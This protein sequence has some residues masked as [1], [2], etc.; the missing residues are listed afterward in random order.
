MGEM[1]GS[2]KQISVK[3]SSRL[4]TLTD[5]MTTDYVLESLLNEH[6]NYKV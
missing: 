3:C 2:C 1:F 6:I 5:I 4:Y